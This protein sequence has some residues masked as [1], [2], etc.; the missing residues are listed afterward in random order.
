MK[1]RTTIA[2]AALTLTTASIV[3]PAD[4]FGII[5]R[6]GGFRVHH[7]RVHAARP[8]RD[9]RA[10]AR[11]ERGGSNKDT[12]VARNKNGAVVVTDK[13]GQKIYIYGPSPKQPLPMVIKRPAVSQQVVDWVM[14]TYA[15]LPK[16]LTDA[17]GPM[18]F[19]VSSTIGEFRKFS[20][21]YDAPD[22]M[23][24]KAFVDYETKGPVNGACK[25]SLIGEHA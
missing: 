11:R 6:F 21:L 5:I 20:Q 13:D 1:L 16:K 24:G 9:R 2:V 4:A 10:V 17:A 15:S 8:H 23:D 25:I 7:S 19:Y 14:P 22:G 12:N 3:T 18:V